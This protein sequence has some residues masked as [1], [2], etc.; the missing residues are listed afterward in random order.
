MTG[1]LIKGSAMPMPQPQ[2]DFAAITGQATVMHR[3]IAGDEEE[4]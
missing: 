1:R 2:T 4:V 3:T